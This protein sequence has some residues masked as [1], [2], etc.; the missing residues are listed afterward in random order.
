MNLKILTPT[1]EKGSKKM[2]A[3]FD[4]PV[5]P[6]LIRR[7]VEAVMANERQQYGADPYAGKRHAVKLSRRRRDY[8]GAYGAGISRVPRKILSRNGT[9]MNWRG[10][11]AP[12][13]VG[14]RRAHPPKAERIFAKKL[15]I[16]ERRKAIRSALAATI[17]KDV[18]QKR[19]HKIPANYPFIIDTSME[20]I[21]KTSDVIDALLK[22]KLGEELERASVKKIRSGIGKTRGRPYQ[23]RIGPLIVVSKDCPLRK[24]ASNIPGVTVVSVEKLNAYMLAPGTHP[25]RLTLYTDAA[26]ER[27]AKEGL[28]R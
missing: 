12:G 1:S 20:D 22:F 23:T 21:G 19:G 25:G 7:A 8:K 14:G 27:I 16:K 3:Q 15:N 26:I 9:Q 10:A 28:F 11:F 17:D 18:V 2:P 5:R 24:A 4:E 13:M 6:D